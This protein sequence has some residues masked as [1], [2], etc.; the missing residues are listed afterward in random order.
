MGDINRYDRIYGG[1]KTILQGK[2]RRNKPTV[3]SKIGKTPLSLQISK[4]QK[5]TSMHG[6]FLC[7]WFDIL[8]Q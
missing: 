7:G 1:E 2:R 8:T 6:H 3:H 5:L 4:I